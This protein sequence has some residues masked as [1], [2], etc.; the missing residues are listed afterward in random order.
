MRLNTKSVH[1]FMIASLRCGVGG[2]IV[3]CVLT[4]TCM[5]RGVI[6]TNNYQIKIQ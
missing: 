3:K 1:L 5:L 4:A 2:S 6:G